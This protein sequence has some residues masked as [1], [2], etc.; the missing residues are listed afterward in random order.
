[1]PGG[2]R[3]TQK[4]TGRI[5]LAPIVI[6]SVLVHSEPSGQRHFLRGFGPR[7]PPICASAVLVPVMRL[8]DEVSDG[9]LRQTLCWVALPFAI[10]AVLVPLGGVY[11]HFRHYQKPVLQRYVVRIYLMIP[12]YAIVSWL[13][14]Q[15]PDY[16]RYFI[17][18]RDCY[19][20]FVIGTFFLLVV[21]YVGGEL[22]VIERFANKAP[23]ER[24]NMCF[25]I[26]R[27]PIVLSD[28]PEAVRVSFGHFDGM[29]PLTN[30]AL[31][32]LSCDQLIARTRMSPELCPREKADTSICRYDAAD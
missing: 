4:R 22:E 25:C 17:P 32:A 5:H 20:A 8:F 28:R 23:L 29:G 31:A 7:G 14:L 1:M 2:H 18:L 26:P 27:K 24:G 11:Q 10:I 9:A 12:V 3:P 19:Q 6:Y 30:R 16:S 13:S 21:E 15:F